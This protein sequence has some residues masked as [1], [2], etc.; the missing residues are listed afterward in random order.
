[1][2]I[3]ISKE[4]LV[5]LKDNLSDNQSKLFMQLLI[6]E[7]K[8]LNPWLPIESAPKD[9][10]ILLK[11]VNLKVVGEWKQLNYDVGYFVRDRLQYEPPLNQP[12]HYQEI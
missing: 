11:Y 1:M 5:E 8:E 12:T 3:G 9:R 7:C 6:A 10:R 4:R 2:T